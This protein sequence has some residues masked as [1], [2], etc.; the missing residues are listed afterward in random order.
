MSIDQERL[1]KIRAF[2][3]R[4]RTVE[5]QYE[6][7]PLNVDA[8]QSYNR[9][10][11]DTIRSLQ[12]HVQRQED[13][14]RQLR[15]SRQGLKI[16]SRGTEPAARLAQ[17]RRVKKAYDTLLQSEPD[18]PAPDSPLPCLIA[19]RETS[20]VI[21]DS[22]ASISSLRQTLPRDRQQLK[23]E[24]ED[25]EDAKRIHDGLETRIQRIR[26]EQLEK[27]AKDPSELAS[28]LVD[29]KRKRA[30]ALKNSST[31][32]KDALDK[33]IDDHLAPQ[34][35][36]ENLGGPIVGDAMDIPDSTL[37]AGYTSHGKPKKP[38]GTTTRHGD[39]DDDPRQQ[40]IDNLFRRR[41]GGEEHEQAIT[42]KREAAAAAMHA[43]VDSLL[44]AGTSY[45]DLPRE[46][47][48]SRFLV[49]A[50]VAQLHPRD[51]RRIRLIDFGRS[52]DD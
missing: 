46:N 1:G 52:F 2:A 15:A 4:G 37:E 31:N 19:L 20:R 39:D 33:F 38:K 48:A 40:R 41:Q 32:L 47:A 7:D 6:E 36:A 14:L 22:K 27:S 28:D 5:R 43:L 16:T 18:L 42:N 24:R 30:R 3:H 35:A 11:D 23:A 44:E 50:K 10:L 25:F 51:A 29:S 13:A 34:L 17:V 12:D 9:K 45:I 49:R 26:H 21:S 8:I